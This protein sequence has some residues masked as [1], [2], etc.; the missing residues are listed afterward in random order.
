MTFLGLVGLADPVRA[1]VPEAVAVCR[2]AGIRV[3]LITGD[4]ATT[5]CAVAR[6]AGIVP[7]DA[8]PAVLTGDTVT[9][10]G[11]EELKDAL[12]SSHIV[13]ARMTPGLHRARPRPFPYVAATSRRLAYPAAFP[14]PA[15]SIGR[16]A[17]MAG[18]TQAARPCPPR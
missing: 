2:T 10:M 3:M 11:V 12:R 13:F 9:A 17:Q 16:D 6:S 15:A 14:A 1:D 7:G 8:E 5:A 18:L 4:A